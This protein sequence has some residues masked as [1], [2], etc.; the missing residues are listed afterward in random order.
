MT[1]T[2]LPALRPTNGG[3]RQSALSALADRFQIQPDRLMAVLKATVL[4]PTQ[5]HTP[6]DEEVAAFILVANQY[7]LNPFTREIHAFVDPQRGVVPIVGVDGWCRIVNSNAEFDGCEFEEVEDEEGKPYKTTCIMHVRGRG[8]PVK[9][10]ERF[11][12]C[13][14]PSM[15]WNSMPF[16][17]L[18]H[19]AFMQAARIAFS[20]SGIY[21][22][23]EAKDII[24]NA[25]PE[26][27]PLPPGVNRTAAT[28]QKITARQQEAPPPAP[29]TEPTYPDDYPPQEAPSELGELAP[30][31]PE[32]QP[33]TSPDD[34]QAIRDALSQDWESVKKV[35]HDA[36][37]QSEQ[38]TQLTWDQFEKG[39]TR[40]VLV[41]GKKGK[42]GSITMDARVK[43]YSAMR[44]GLFNFDA[45]R[46]AA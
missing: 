38:Y 22:E 11:K 41:L 10:T 25:A 2:A 34:E 40:Y 23:D 42:E 3:A 46:I 27:E 5:K 31:A 4:K 9:V 32:Q 44:D 33:Q 30:P 24:Q 14:R 16:R 39:L 1:T 6:T 18:R 19:K 8:H 37:K 45:G 15:P 7:Q 12:E 35:L 43:L 21:D 13:H 36:T 26:R 20:I 29:A 28:L 17:M